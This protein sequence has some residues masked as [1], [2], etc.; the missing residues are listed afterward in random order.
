MS[1]GRPQIAGKPPAAKRQ[2]WDRV[3]LQ[4]LRR[5]QPCGHLDLGFQTPEL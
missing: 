3:F 5:R 1:Q 2:A 4:A